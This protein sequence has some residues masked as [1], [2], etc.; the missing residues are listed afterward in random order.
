M[1]HVPR[2]LLSDF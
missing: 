2:L 1:D